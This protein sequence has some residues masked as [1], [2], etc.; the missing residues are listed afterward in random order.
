M[1]GGKI[2]HSFRDML[3]QA[4]GMDETHQQ[5]ASWLC[6]AEMDCYTRFKACGGESVVVE[7]GLKVGRL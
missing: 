2:V 3:D 7:R 5:Q 1:C 6:L 4:D